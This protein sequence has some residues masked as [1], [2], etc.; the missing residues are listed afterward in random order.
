MEVLRTP[1]LSVRQPIGTFFVGAMRALDLLAITKFDY[2]RMTYTNGYIDFLGIQRQIDPKRIGVIS[3]Y[4]K[5]ADACFPTS[6]VIA[7]DEPCASI[8]DTEIEGVSILEIR[9]YI[10]DDQRM[11]IPFDQVASII[12]GQHRL[13]GLQESE[14]REFEIGVSIF[15]GV[16]DATEATIFSTVNLAQ[17]KVNR[18]LVYDLFSI[19]RH[20]SPEKTCHEIVVALDRLEESPFRDRIKRLGLATEGRFGETLSQ[21]TVVRG[22]LPYISDD[23]IGDRDRGRRFAYWEPATSKEFGSRI[24]YPFFQKNEDQKILAVLMNFFSSIRDRWPI[25]W[26]STGQGNI[27]NRTNG[28]N[29]FMRFLKPAYFRYTTEPTVVPKASFDALFA[30]IKLEDGDFTV[31]TFSPGTGG[32][33]KLFRTLQEQA[34]LDAS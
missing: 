10:A 21:A 7:V 30:K 9:E 22:I 17:T 18:S 19:S 25:A 24:F 27:I 8:T 14:L 6:V 26:N 3:K 32:S 11:S 20:R 28:F 13:K 15:V 29:G 16:D 34:E 12:D 4:V 2:R 23:P 5:T 31:E 1:V 33:S